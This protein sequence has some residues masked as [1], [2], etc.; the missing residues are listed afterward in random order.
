MNFPTWGKPRNVQ[1]DCQANTLPLSLPSMTGLEK[2]FKKPI[3]MPQSRSEKNF[4]IWRR[5]CF[6]YLPDK[7]LFTKVSPGQR[8]PGRW[9][10]T[11][12]EHLPFE[13]SI[14]S[15][16]SFALTHNPYRNL[17]LRQCRHRRLCQSHSSSFSC[18]MIWAIALRQSHTERNGQ[19][20]N[21]PKLLPNSIYS[22]SHPRRKYLT[23]TYTAGRV[24]RQLPAPKPGATNFVYIVRVHSLALDMMLHNFNARARGV[25]ATWPKRLWYWPLI[26]K[27]SQ[28]LTE[29]MTRKWSLHFLFLFTCAKMFYPASHSATH[30]KGRSHSLFVMNINI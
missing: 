25:Y 28:K 23:D 30:T 12:S 1:F 11:E 6:L 8:R 16:S 10:E 14:D 29:C 22:P 7:F 4:V 27:Q 19:P 2:C 13:C 17:H 18:Q 5:F 21:G 9:R 26:A 20:N 15:D 3:K 24:S